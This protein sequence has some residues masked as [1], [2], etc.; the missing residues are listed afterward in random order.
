MERIEM[1]RSVVQIIHEQPEWLP[2]AGWWRVLQVVR[3]LAMVPVL[4]VAVVVLFGE[5]DLFGGGFLVLASLGVFMAAHGI[6][7]TIAWIYHGFV[8]PEAK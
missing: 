8:Q 2:H 1:K 7:W 5:N 3:L 4:F 6:G